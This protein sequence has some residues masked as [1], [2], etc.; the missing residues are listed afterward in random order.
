MFIKMRNPGGAS[1]K[2]TSPALVAASP[3]Q[4]VPCDLSVAA[5][6]KLI[7]RRSD[8]VLFIYRVLD[9]ANPAP[10]PK[11]GPES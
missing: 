5:V 10:L 4:A 1:K 9:P 8:D 3:P 11:L 6:K 2:P 7:W